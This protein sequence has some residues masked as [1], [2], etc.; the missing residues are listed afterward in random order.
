MNQSKK[1]DLTKESLHNDFVG[2]RREVNDAVV[3]TNNCVE[4]LCLQS[5]FLPSFRMLHKH[6]L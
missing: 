2:R 3:L 5:L 1:D 6:S 4:T